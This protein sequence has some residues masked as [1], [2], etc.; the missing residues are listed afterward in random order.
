MARKRSAIDFQFGECIGEGSYSK[1]YRGVS[2][3]NHRTYAIKIL[4]KSHIHRENK[5]KYVNI[6]KDTLNILGKHPG[7][8]TL[9]YTFQDEKS[10]YFVID[11][12][13]NG[14]LLSL[15]RKMGSLSETLSKYYFVQLI[16]AVEFIHSKG[17]IHRDLKPENV[18]LNHEWKLMITDFGAAK[19]LSQEERANGCS[20]QPMN[21]IGREISNQSSNGSFVGTAEYVSPELLKYNICG[22][23]CDLWALGCILYQ[24]IVG[25]PPFKGQTEYLTFEKIIS[26]DYSFPKNYFVPPQIEQVIRSLLVVE[27][28]K[29]C[30]IEDL[31]MQPWLQNID[32]DNKDFIW[33]TKVPKLEAYNPRLQNLL[34]SR[35]TSSSN[36]SLNFYGPPDGKIIGKTPS[37]P[38]HALKRQIM[39]AQNNPQLMNKVLSH[40][41]AE[42]DQQVKNRL[43][44]NQMAPV[45]ANT[46]IP[47]SPISSELRNK[48]D[49]V[50]RRN[51]LQ[52]VNGDSS[53]ITPPASEPPSPS[54]TS[55][56]TTLRIIDPRHSHE[57]TSSIK[58]PPLSTNIETH[59]SNSSPL[60]TFVKR[61][62]SESLSRS[63]SSSV[64]VKT[65][66]QSDRKP[67]MRAPSI[68]ELL[69]IPQ[70][71]S[72]A[73]SAA[74]A[75]GNMMSH[76]RAL[77]A[78]QSVSS[79]QYQQQQQQQMINPI[80]LDKQIPKSITSK[81]MANEYI[82]KLD[83]ILKSE[84]T[85]K[86]NQ[87]VPQG[88]T[89]DD[90]ILNKVIT[91]NYQSL[92]R[93]L[94]SC[95]LIITSMARLLIYEINSD[96]KL[97]NPQSSTQLQAMD[98]YSKIVE[99]K[100]TNRNVSMYDYEFDE[101]L[102]EG[103]LILELMN[104]N[105]LIFLSAYDS[106]TLVRGGINSNVRVGFKVNE[107]V[108]WIDS[109]L[110]ARE[111]LRQSKETGP[112]SATK[113]KTNTAPKRASRPGSAS[114]LVRRSSSQNGTVS[115]VSSGIRQMDLS[116]KSSAAAAAA[117][118]IGK[119]AH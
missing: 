36:S 58:T 32:W 10:L 68:N 21:E 64:L 116:D 101:E 40:R 75:I 47:K 51:S 82:L 115:S 72:Q 61:V 76:K 26:L 107:S 25:R 114:K 83:N 59:S 112:D 3:H 88:Y 63:S 18:L 91:E 60:Q 23:E 86:P 77:Q 31:K 15:I 48:N 42:K 93:D 8:V 24:F 69:G 49:I 95:V 56:R 78:S 39:N 1:V 11:F 27:P 14:E 16:D 96:F 57:K 73:V 6:E 90:N 50:E 20:T 102:K 35:H 98:F 33:R 111:L 117:M 46:S 28:E 100:L 41:L 38:Q 87:F 66:D 103:Y 99:V 110:K 106:K 71:S 119:N 13:K 108:S 85:H 109:L 62:S 113:V 44:V 54:E 55:L 17:I 97:Q 22:F 74:G 2:I 52:F 7:I 81:L 67:I 70:P 94:K 104:M 65:G 43:L 89:L 4:S 29:R 12:A 79:S 9:Y 5:R 105:K 84:L 53:S 34:Q 30:K 37:V 45:A 118:A 92:N 19:I 80:L